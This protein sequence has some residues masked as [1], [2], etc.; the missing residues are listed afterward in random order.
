MLAY[1]SFLMLM[2][3]LSSDPGNT[4]TAEGI[5]T[6]VDTTP[7]NPVISDQEQEDQNCKNNVEM[8]C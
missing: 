4:L 7:V 2:F 3:F 6:S 1:L 5:F 8:F